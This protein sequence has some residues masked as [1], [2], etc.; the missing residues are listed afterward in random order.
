MEHAPSDKDHP[1]SIHIHLTSGIPRGKHLISVI[2]HLWSSKS[3]TWEKCHVSGVDS[4]TKGIATH[5]FYKNLVTH[6]APRDA[7]S[8]RSLDHR[9]GSVDIRTSHSK[10][11]DW[12][13]AETTWHV[14]AY[15]MECNSCL[16]QGK[17]SIAKERWD[18]IAI[19]QCSS[20]NQDRIKGSSKPHDLCI[21]WQVT[22]R[23]VLMDGLH[24]KESRRDEI[25]E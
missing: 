20:I 5:F 1:H 18:R 22:L 8:R 3:K 14:F 2:S 7:C 25:K 9:L 15:R 23:T 6:P 11:L 24:S 12:R 13:L 17:V 4:R 21:S 19:R 10:T 16:G